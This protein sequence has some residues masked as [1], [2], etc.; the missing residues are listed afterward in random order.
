MGIRVSRIVAAV[1]IA[2]AGSVLTVTATNSTENIKRAAQE[3][4]HVVAADTPDG[5]VTWGP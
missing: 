5:D 4:Q 3:E 2:F 1:L